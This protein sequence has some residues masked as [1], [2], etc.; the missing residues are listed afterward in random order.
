MSGKSKAM[1]NRLVIRADADSRTG[2]GHV[3][4]CIALG[5]AW[6]DAGR[7]EVVFVCCCDADGVKKRI[8]EEGFRL[9]E[10][11]GGGYP[12]FEGDI[13]QT[14]K[15]AGECKAGWIAIDGYHFDLRYQQAVRAGGYKLL[16]T[17]DYCHLSRYEADILLNQNLNYKDFVYTINSDCVKCFGIEYALIRREFRNRR[18][19]H[20]SGSSDHLLVLMGGG[21]LFNVTLKVLEILERAELN[22]LLIKVVLGPANPHKAVLRQFARHSCLNIELMNEVRDMPALIEWAGFAISAAGSICAEFM[23][24]KLPAGLIITA[25]NQRREAFL[26]RQTG[27]FDLL[28]DFDTFKESDLLRCIVNRAELGRADRISGLKVAGRLFDLV[29]QMV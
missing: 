26:L 22:E 16:Y 21:D 20:A 4:R 1:R 15:I 8:I 24:M 9:I 11:Q 14:L 12:D 10:L 29:Q 28:G 13:G 7:G 25:E 19:S 6:Q 3:M 17:D 18:P 27:W 2:T 5:Q 23:Y